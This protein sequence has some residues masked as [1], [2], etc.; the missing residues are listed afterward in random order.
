MIRRQSISD[1]CNKKKPYLKYYACYYRV[2]FKLVGKYVF[3]IHRP[4]EL[5]STYV[6]SI[7]LVHEKQ[8]LK[9]NYV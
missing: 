2:N 4:L 5:V 3:W 8:S 7:M 9:S 6:I 1:Y